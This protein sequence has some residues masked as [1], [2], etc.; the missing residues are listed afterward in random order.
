MKIRKHKAVEKALS[1]MDKSAAKK[2]KHDLK[3]E[4]IRTLKK[5]Y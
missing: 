5:L 2:Q 1:L 4:R 3:T